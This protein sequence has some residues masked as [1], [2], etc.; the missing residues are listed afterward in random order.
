M[1]QAVCLFAQM[2]QG[3]AGLIKIGIYVLS[4]AREK[5][6]VNVRDQL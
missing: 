1:I 6:T 4:E 3:Q 2:F 5:N